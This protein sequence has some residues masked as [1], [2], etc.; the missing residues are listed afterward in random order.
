MSEAAEELRAALLAWPP[1]VS[2]VGS[3]VREDLGVEGD[4]Y[5]FVVFKQVGDIPHRNLDGSLHARQETFQ[6]ESWGMT[7]AQSA[8]VHRVV[9]DALAAAG[10]APEAADPNALDPEIGARAGVWNVD[11]WH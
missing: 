4:A 5:P 3:R 10:L 11:I 7:R 9:E 1:L 2:L 8:Q 6:V